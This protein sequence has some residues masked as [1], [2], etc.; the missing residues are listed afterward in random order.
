[1]QDDTK[2]NKLVRYI[3]M[4]LFLISL[5]QKAYCTTDS[6]S[7]SFLVFLL[8]WAAAFTSFAGTSW[9]ANPLLILSWILLGKKLKLAMLL[10]VGAFIL[11]LSFLLAGEVTANE[12]GQQ[13][14]IVSRNAGYWLWLT[15]MLVMVFG[16]FWLQLKENTQK[17]HEQ[18]KQDQQSTNY[19]H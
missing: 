8:G 2:T 11:A 7:D 9:L 5:T 3:S 13:H 6:C 15:S 18:R 16:T 10:C 14:Q 17:F 19:L 1:M 4:M 12:N